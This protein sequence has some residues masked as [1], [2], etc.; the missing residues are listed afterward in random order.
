MI[1][2]HEREHG[3]L[4]KL[5]LPTPPSSPLPPPPQIP[6]ATGAD[7][8]G[9][10]EGT[11]ASPPSTAEASRGGD[12]TAAAVIPGG[13]EGDVLWKSTREERQLYSRIARRVEEALLRL[14]AEAR[15]DLGDR[16][17]GLPAEAAA[18]LEAKAA[19]GGGGGGR[20]RREERG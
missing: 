5:A 2:D 14:E 3:P 10:R 19:G 17:P 12:T 7:G 15:R 8:R 18:M 20:E 1:E 16:Y 13:R 9:R 6:S 11:E 4:R